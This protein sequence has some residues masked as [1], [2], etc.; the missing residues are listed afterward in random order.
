ME[1]L[2]IAPHKNH[3]GSSVSTSGMTKMYMQKMNMQKKIL[4]DSTVVK[5]M[6]NILF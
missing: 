4:T 5:Q 3:F 1:E 6:N 2:I